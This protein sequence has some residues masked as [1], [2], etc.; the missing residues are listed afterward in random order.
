MNEIAAQAAELAARLRDQAARLTAEARA[1][2]DAADGASSVAGPEGTVSVTVTGGRVDAVAIDPRALRGPLPEL[3]SA[4]ARAVNQALTA[5]RDRAGSPGNTAVSASEAERFTSRL[6]DERISVRSADRQV[7]VTASGTGEIQ[8]V[9]IEETARQHSGGR[10]L[11]DSIA[12]ACNQALGA[13]QRLQ[14]RELDALRPDGGELDAVLEDR[15]RQHA[16]QMDTLLDRLADLHRRI[17]D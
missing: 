16:R 10:R 8:A 6:A 13:A 1:D 7:T 2:G 11:G 5:A 4:A 9:R 14:Q 17:G 12:S 15:V 3:E